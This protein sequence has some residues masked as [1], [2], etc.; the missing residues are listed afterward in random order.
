MTPGPL[1]QTFT[2][3]LTGEATGPTGIVVPP[4]IIA[5]LGPKKTPSVQ[6]GF[7]VHQYRSTVAVRGGRFMIPVS[8][9]ERTAAAMRSGPESLSRNPEAPAAMPSKRCSSSSKVVMSTTAVEGSVTMRRVA[10]MPSSVVC[11][12]IK[13]PLVARSITRAAMFTSTP[14]QSEPIR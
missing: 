8:A 7:A 9:A 3:R 11:D 13:P 6:V 12:T 5:A 1:P 14:S 2:A 10:A 4:E